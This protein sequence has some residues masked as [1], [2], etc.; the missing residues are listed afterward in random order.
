M[1]FAS[2]RLAPRNLALAFSMASNPRLGSNSS[3]ACTVAILVPASAVVDSTPGRVLRAVWTL[4][5]HVIGQ[6]MP[7]ILNATVC[8][9][10]DGPVLL[11]A[12]SSVMAL[13]VSAVSVAVLP[14]PTKKQAIAN[15]VRVLCIKQLLE[16]RKQMG[17]NILTVTDPA[18]YR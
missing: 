7:G 13:L 12:A 6:V 4:L 9:G 10:A 17:V 15:P 3:V 11:F 1:S 5:V 18:W 14:Q 2:I 16:S 8:V